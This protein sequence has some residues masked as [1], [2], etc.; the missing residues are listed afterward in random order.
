[1]FEK[2]LPIFFFRSKI[3]SWDSEN[4]ELDHWWSK[5]G[6]RACLDTKVNY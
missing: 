6:I 4:F 1:M 5:V 2:G 3:R